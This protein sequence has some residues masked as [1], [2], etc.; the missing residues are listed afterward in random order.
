M[1]RDSHRMVCLL[2]LVAVALGHLALAT[3]PS[4]YTDKN[5]YFSVIPPAGWVKKEFNDP[6][7]KVSF[8]VP[9]PAAG[10]NKAGLFF[11]SH[12]L[13]GTIDMRAEAENRV[14]RLKQM[15][16]PD[17]RVTTVD[18]AGVKAEQV[19]GQMGR[20]NAYLRALMFTNYGRSYTVSFT[21]TKQDFA[22]YWPTAEEALKTFK[23]IPPEGVEVAA[24]Q[25][26]V[27]KQKI[28]VWIT[29]LK[30][31]DLGADAFDSLLAVGQPAIPQLEEAGRTGTALQKQRAAD[32][33]KR[34]RAQGK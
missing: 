5:G 9:A 31:A 17:A 7:S 23:C 4:A 18:F 22:Q 25:K 1:K 11:L 20:Q 34:I 15:G 6:R 33:L 10:Q 30:E 21:A 24:D 8:D 12:P 3:E 13:S 26:E 19:D 27:Q 32:L 16:S 28:R 2:S 14:A 29:A